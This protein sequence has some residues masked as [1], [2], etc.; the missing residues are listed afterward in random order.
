MEKFSI[1]LQSLVRKRVNNIT[2]ICHN[3]I[4]SVRDGILSFKSHPLLSS[5]DYTLWKKYILSLPIRCIDCSCLTPLA[6]HKIISDNSS[7][8]S[9]LFDKKSADI[10]SV[11]LS[12]YN[13][14]ELICPDILPENFCTNIVNDSVRIYRSTSFTSHLSKIFPNVQWLT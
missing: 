12:R 5:K 3:S 2:F 10:V 4:M 7:I 11:Y 8:I 6:L 9:I 13:I 14:Q 1:V